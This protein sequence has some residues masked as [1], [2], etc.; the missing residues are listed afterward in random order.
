MGNKSFGKFVDLD[1][2]TILQDRLWD[3]SNDDS[4]CR[5]GKKLRWIKE[6]NYNNSYT[7]IKRGISVIRI[8]LEY[9]WL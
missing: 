4:K 2:R 1:G 7:L 3:N 9:P 8:M 6:N 5:Y